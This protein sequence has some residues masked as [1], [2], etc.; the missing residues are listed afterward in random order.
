MNYASHQLKL[1]LE[2]SKFERICF[3]TFY[4]FDYSN[5]AKAVQMRFCLGDIQCQFVGRTVLG[6]DFSFSVS[7][8]VGN[9]LYIIFKNILTLP[10]T[11]CHIK[12]GIILGSRRLTS[13]IHLI[14]PLSI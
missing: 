11:K 5:R 7:F 6:L 2:V 3:Y 4:T 1:K 9:F 12:Y 14:C 10:M 8:N 13:N